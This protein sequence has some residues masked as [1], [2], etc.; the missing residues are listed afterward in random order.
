MIYDNILPDDYRPDFNHLVLLK[1]MIQKLWDL[2]FEA[3]CAQNFT[4]SD[5]YYASADIL[6]KAYEDIYHKWFAETNEWAAKNNS[7]PF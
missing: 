5:T 3:L 6:R 1:G 7:T 2:S 4:A